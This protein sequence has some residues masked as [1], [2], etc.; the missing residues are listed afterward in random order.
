MGNKISSPEFPKE[1][2]GSLIV[3][4]RSSNCG[5][6]VAK[7]KCLSIYLN[8]SHE[9]FCKSRVSS[10][11]NSTETSLTVN[12]S[13]HIHCV[14]RN[15]SRPKVFFSAI[16]TIAVDMVEIVFGESHNQ[17]MKK[18]HLPIASRNSG[19]GI[20]ISPRFCYRPLEMANH[21]RILVVDKC[22]LALGEWNNNHSLIIHNSGGIA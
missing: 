17:T 11:R 16:K 9:S 12:A 1:F 5:F 3:S 19:N 20:A 15:G 10:D 8:L 2:M 22:R 13:S 6:K 18:D 21:I 7:E 14:L 4:L